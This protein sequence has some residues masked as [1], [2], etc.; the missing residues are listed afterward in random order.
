MLCLFFLLLPS[1]SSAQG[2]RL[3]L[4]FTGDIMVHQDQL[5]AARR[6]G[7]K[8]EFSESFT[9]VQD[10]L[11]EAHLAVGNLELTFTSEPPYAGYPAFQTPDEL[12]PALRAAGFGLLL[13]A[14][15]HANDGG[16]D[17]IKHTLDVLDENHFYHTGTYASL[18]EKEAF[19]PL[20]VYKNGFKLAFLNYTY[21]LNAPHLRAPTLANFMEEAEMR[22]D[23]ETARQLRADAIIVALHWGE[24]YAHSPT[25]RQRELA[26]NL[27]E[28]GADMII[29]A[30]PH[31]V[32]PVEWIND[33]WG[34]PKLVAYSLGNF[35][36]GMRL[37]GTDGGIILEV[38]LVKEELGTRIESCRFVPIWCYPE[39]AGDGRRTY[40][41]LPAAPFE[42]N[43]SLPF[44]LPR[45]RQNSLNA[46]ARRTREIMA[47][48]ACPERKV[49][50]PIVQKEQYDRFRNSGGRPQ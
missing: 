49:S 37:P 21:G 2:Q 25:S 6:P 24:E 18:L 13:T 23:I 5:D 9:Y 38:E 7:G 35:F 17:G 45:W 34:E 50:L 42:E 48:S 19:H 27:V 41:V 12:A 43:D 36:S 10:V 8:Y 4:A 28:W 29:G 47:Q 31:V 32:Q 11:R 15:N 40:R 44:T 30:H 16:G 1:L 3:Q 20:I 26:R 22:K 14:N 46:F 39:H 33:R